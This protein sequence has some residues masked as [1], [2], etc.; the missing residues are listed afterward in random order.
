MASTGTPGA[1]KSDWPGPDPERLPVMIGFRKDPGGTIQEGGVS[2]LSPVSP[3]KIAG[4]SQDWPGHAECCQRISGEWDL[5]GFAR[6]MSC[7]AA[8]QVF[9]TLGIHD[10]IKP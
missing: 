4:M 2:C 6:S 1:R 5:V 10:L 8:K 9:N 3:D 7:R